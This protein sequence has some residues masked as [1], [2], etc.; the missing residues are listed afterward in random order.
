MSAPTF[1]TAEWRGGGTPTVPPDDSEESFITE[2]YWGY[3]RQRDG[4][5]VEYRVESAR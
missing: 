2:H 4:A 1:L 3:A 5:T